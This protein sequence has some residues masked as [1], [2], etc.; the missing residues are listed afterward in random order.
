MFYCFCFASH[1][2]LIIS[3]NFCNV[4][5]M[6][7]A[8]LCALTQTVNHDELFHLTGAKEVMISTL[9]PSDPAAFRPHGARL[10]FFLS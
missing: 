3:G 2:C 4:V 10:R 1:L 6:V 5:A 8:D 7:R 9:T